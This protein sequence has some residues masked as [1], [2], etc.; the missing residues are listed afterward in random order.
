MVVG[1]VG[2]PHGVRGEVLLHPGSGEAS[3]FEVGRAFDTEHGR[4]TVAGFRR[5]HGALIIQFEEVSSRDGAESLRGL[6]IR[7]RTDAVRLD[8]D[9][10][11]PSDL[12]ACQAVTPEGTV[13]GEV[14]DVVAGT[15]QDRLLI[16]TGSGEEV[17]VPFVT[18]L[19]PEVDTVARRVVIIAPDGLF[20]VG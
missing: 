15:A 20:P 14:V 11:W 16:R 17:E 12:L 13:L 6:A 3:V 10:W 5:H 18:D 9:E 2:K 8:A 4:L 1:R 7:A 19:V